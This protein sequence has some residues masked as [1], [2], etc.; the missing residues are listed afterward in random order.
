MDEIMRNLA[1]PLGVGLFTL[2]AW[3]WARGAHRRARARARHE[4]YPAE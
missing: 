3:A 2:V 4:A 1:P